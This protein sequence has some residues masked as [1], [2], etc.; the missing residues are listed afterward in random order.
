MSAFASTLNHSVIPLGM[1]P[2]SVRAVCCR[3]D[4]LTCEPDD[5]LSPR[6]REQWTQM[7]AVEKRR[8][9]WLL[10]R[11]AAKSAV[12]MLAEKLS[13]KEIGIIPDAYGCPRVAG[14]PVIS[15][16]HSRVSL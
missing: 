14:G 7:R 15:I 12:G 3:L 4:S 5:M 10:G 6:E 16:A 13:L 11:C 2:E 8:Q 1:L 9:E